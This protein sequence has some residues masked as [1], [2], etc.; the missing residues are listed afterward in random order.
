[1]LIENQE[2]FTKNLP[3]EARVLGLDVGDTTIGLALSDLR[4]SISTPLLTIER[5]KFSKDV[6]QLKTIINTQ[7][8]AGLVIG[9]PINMDGSKGTRVQSTRSFV[10]NISKHF[11]LPMLFWD[12]RFSSMVVE[13]M[14][15]QA[16]MSRKRRAELVDKL[17]ASYMLQ[18]Y[19]DKARNSGMN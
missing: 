9:Y 13:K 14:M 18:G 8:I 2:E 15:K 11:E 17:A 19:L 6:E 16:D 10:S 5:K 12:E 3:S 7:K 1:M 4:R